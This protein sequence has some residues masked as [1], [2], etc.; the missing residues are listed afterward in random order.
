MNARPPRTVGE[1]VADISNHLLD[2]CD[3]TTGVVGT[4]DAY[5]ETPLAGYIHECQQLLWKEHPRELD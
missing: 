2:F 4:V 5:I 3:E 1:S